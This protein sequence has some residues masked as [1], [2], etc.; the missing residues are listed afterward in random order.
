M[1]YLYHLVPEGMRGAVLYPLNQLKEVYPE[2]YEAQ[3]KKYHGRESTML[4]K[5][6]RLDCLWNDALHLTAVHP[7]EVKD[8]MLAA[9]KESSWMKSYYQIDAASLVSENASV[10]LYVSAKTR[11]G[12]SESEFIAYAPEDV[13]TYARLPQGTKDYYKEVIVKGGKPLLFHLVPH[14]LYKGEIDVKDAP[15]ITV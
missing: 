7:Q 8:A 3:A 6:P 11:E 10:Y 4:Q 5:I 13:S 9:G 2:A 14:I 1:N 15:I 12:A